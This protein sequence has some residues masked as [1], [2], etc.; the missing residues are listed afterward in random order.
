MPQSDRI[1]AERLKQSSALSP[2]LFKM[3][4]ELLKCDSDIAYSPTKLVEIFADPP[5]LWAGIAN[6]FR[7]DAR[8]FDKFLL[9]LHF[10][11]DIDFDA[12]QRERILRFLV[13]GYLLTDDIRYFNEFLFFHREA[14]PDYMELCC[15]HFQVNLL[16]GGRHRFPGVSPS[17]V[18]KFIQSLNY[19]DSKEQAQIK[20]P[21]REKA[22]VALYGNPIGFVSLRRRLEGLGLRCKNYHL[23][24]FNSSSK[25]AYS[26]GNFKRKLWRSSILSKLILWLKGERYSFRALKDDPSSIRLRDILK[27]DKIDIALHRLYGV[28]RSNL[29]EGSGVGILNDHVGVLPYLRGWSTI[30]Y[31]ILFGF[32]VGATVHFIDEGVDTGPIIKIFVL[33]SGQFGESLSNIVSRLCAGSEDRILRT[34]DFLF[35]DRPVTVEIQNNQGYQFFQMHDHL[36]KYV[37]DLC[38]DRV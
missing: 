27:S 2:R 30:E 17:D 29:I 34:I 9:R 19:A 36:K 13:L 12:T 14:F 22:T 3:R 8:S 32:P 5:F 6:A 16:D 33:E 37:E 26:R 35:H 28:I 11:R 15:E 4:K 7:I 38:L 23:T 25:V 18:Y 24:M 31:A 1:L 21:K 20:L 10:K